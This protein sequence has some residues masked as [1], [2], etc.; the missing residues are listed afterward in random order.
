[1]RVG[2]LHRP[3][4]PA[5]SRLAVYRREHDLFAELIQQSDRTFAAEEPP[6][7]LRPPERGTHLDPQPDRLTGRVP[8]QV[9]PARWRD[10]PRTWPGLDGH[11]VNLE[12]RTPIENLPAF[13]RPR[14]RVSHG[15]YSRSRPRHLHAE[16]LIG[17]DDELD[18][19]PRPLVHDHPDSLAAS[20]VPDRRGGVV[21]RA[22]DRWRE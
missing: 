18:N 9:G 21:A 22:V 16:Q 3:P 8:C 10:H 2:R 11:A 14:M 17:F 7:E 12:R 5:S 19:L 1:M 13:L 15:P 20:T 6:N 4:P